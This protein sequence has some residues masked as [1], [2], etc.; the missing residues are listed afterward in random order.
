VIGDV[1]TK[2]QSVFR[3]SKN[4]DTLTA[5]RMDLSYSWTSR[6]QTGISLK[7]QNRDRAFN[8]DTANNSGW[9]DVAI[10]Q[11]FQAPNWRRLWYFQ[12]LNIPTANSNYNSQEK[13]AIDAH[14]T[15]TYQLSM[16]VFSVSNFKE[17]DV[18]LGPEVHY[19]F[20]RN[21]ERGGDRVAVSGAAGTGVLVGA[22]YI[23]WR[24]KMRYGV[25]LNPKYEGPKTVRIN[26]EPT[27]S[28]SSL[29]WDSSINLTYTLSA[30]YSIGATYLDQTLFGPVQNTI[31]VRSVSALFQAR[32]P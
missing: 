3:N 24:S 6:Y 26:D 19:S 23:P 32:W 21:F 7:Y 1:D 29:V 10:S 11:A 22:G 13:L 17:W 9:S 14:G 31:L 12:S 30:E 20:A 27:K 28:E 5:M 16:G 18:L 25:S 4:K 8:G 15:G 2:R